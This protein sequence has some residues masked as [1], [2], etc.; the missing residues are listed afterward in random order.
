M[1]RTVNLVVTNTSTPAE[2]GI[3]TEGTEVLVGEQVKEPIRAIPRISY[4]DIGGLPPVIQKNR[5]MIELP[6]RHPEFFER[7]GGEGPK[8][9]LLHAPPGTGETLLARAGAG[10]TDADFLSIR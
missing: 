7:L 6:P 4:E 2:A 10:E 5:E 1:G 8:G 3:G 9:V